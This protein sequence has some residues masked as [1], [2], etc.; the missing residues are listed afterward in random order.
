MSP[1]LGRIGK[2]PRSPGAASPTEGLGAGWKP[3]ESN[4]SNNHGA[5]VGMPTH[6]LP[7]GSPIAP[8]QS[9]VPGPT[10]PTSSNGR[11]STPSPVSSSS[12]CTPSNPISTTYQITPTGY[13]IFGNDL[14]SQQV[15]RDMEELLS[16]LFPG[17]TIHTGRA[18]L[19]EAES[20]LLRLA[21]SL[22][23]AFHKRWFLLQTARGDYD[24]LRGPNGSMSLFNVEAL[25]RAFKIV[26]SSGA[27]E[28]SLR[29]GREL[30]REAER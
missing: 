9:F 20:Q 19:A 29:R 11:P 18:E 5:N 6:N 3:I 17:T 8:Q 10:I 30:E 22:A 21:Q 25:Q 16:V 15:R 12:T 28:G 7:V 24:D 26:G 23:V 2:D 27:A 1:P 13:V 14:R 4:S